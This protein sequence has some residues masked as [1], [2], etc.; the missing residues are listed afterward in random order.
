MLMRLFILQVARWLRL[1]SKNKY[2]EKRAIILISGSKLFSAKW[3]RK[4]Y[5]NS[6]KNAAKHY[7][8]QGWLEGYNPS[9]R[10]DGNAYLR[11]NV[12]VREMG[13]NPLYHYITRGAQ[14][15]R[16]FKNIQGQVKKAKKSH[17]HMRL[18]TK[19]KY[20][21]TYPERVKEKL[22]ELKI[23]KMNNKQA[24]KSFYWPCGI[25]FLKSYKIL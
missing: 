18:N 23:R 7:Y 4:H 9:K 20:I 15:G 14:E 1:I 3:Y 22:N 13:I 12:D 25:T 19:I 24:K 17:G 11:D 6:K 2:R 21:L 10:F 5:P 8:K 16:N